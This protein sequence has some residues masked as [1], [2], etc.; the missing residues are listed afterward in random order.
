MNISEQEK[1]RIRGLHKSSSTI[2]E[3]VSVDPDMGVMLDPSQDI[4]AQLKQIMDKTN[5]KV[6]ADIMVVIELASREDMSPHEILDRM[7]E[8]A[9]KLQNNEY[10]TI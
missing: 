10:L 7:G 2:K 8:I 6:L 3:Q 1:N 4:K 9:N 5:E